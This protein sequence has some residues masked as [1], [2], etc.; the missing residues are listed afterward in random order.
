MLQTTLNSVA[1][2]GRFLGLDKGQIDDFS[3]PDAVWQ[4]KLKLKN[5]SSF[6][7]FRVQHNN[8]Y[9]PYKGGLRFSPTVNAGHSQALAT[10]MSL[11]NS[12]LGLPLGGGKGGINVDPGKLSRSE[13]EELARGYVGRFIAHLGPQT[14]IAAPDINTNPEIIDWMAAEYE[15]LTGDRR[16]AAF[17]GKSLGAG[18]SQGRLEATGRGG[19]IVLDQ[20]NHMTGGDAGRHQSRRL[21][22]QGFGNVGAAFVEA[23][24]RDWR[25]WQIVAVSDKTTALKSVDGAELPLG[26]IIDHHRDQGHLDGFSHPNVTNI[27]QQELLDM[28]VDVLVL[29]AVEDTI[30]ATN[31]AT[32]KAPLI[33]E[34]ANA[35]ISS[36]ADKA[37]SR[38]QIKII[39]DLVGSGGGVIV[40]YLEVCQNLANQSWSLETVNSHLKTIITAAAIDVYRLAEAR[41]L[42]WRQAAFVYGLK[43]FFEAPI[44]FSPALVANQP[45]LPPVY[46]GP[47]SLEGVDWSGRVGQP[48]LALAA[49]VVIDNS[50]G[51]AGRDLIIEHRWGIRTLYQQLDLATNI[52]KTGDSVRAGQVIGK[53]GRPRPKTTEKPH[54]HLKIHRHYQP[55]DPKPYIDPT[56]SLSSETG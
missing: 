33:L 2:A 16:R 48:V 23:V 7:G 18:G 30:T 56:D 45:R 28:A 25:Q 53:I 10:L 42:T 26:A 37:L 43:Q 49:G 34:M 39:P 32:I 35:P 41:D 3:Q 22:V 31:E 17:T 52:V 38:R 12:C 40:S 24:H 51:K 5:G 50:P 21:A 44:E 13:L 54:F 27:G 6:S 8:R 20:F 1:G 55:V 19:A 29:A 15:R 11:K 9:G 36:A 14:D 46:S 47:D 4:A